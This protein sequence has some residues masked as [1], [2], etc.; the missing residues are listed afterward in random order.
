MSVFINSNLNTVR[1]HRDGEQHG[2]QVSSWGSAAFCS[3]GW[4]LGLL[5]T[6]RLFVDAVGNEPNE[7]MKVV[8]MRQNK[9]N[10]DMSLEPPE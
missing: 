9:S 2:W 6:A 5:G 3:G 10:G 8:R 1:P 4:M 7:L